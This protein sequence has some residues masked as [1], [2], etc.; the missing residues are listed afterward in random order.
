MIAVKDPEQTR[1]AFSGEGYGVPGESPGRSSLSLL[2]AFPVT[3]RI[4]ADQLLMQ[5]VSNKE[6]APRTRKHAM[7]LSSKS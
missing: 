7:N 4:V 2:S 6:H 5:S 1:K 3:P